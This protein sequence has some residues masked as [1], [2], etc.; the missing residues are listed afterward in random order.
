M[1]G[2]KHTSRF[3]RD[4]R[5]EKMIRDSPVEALERQNTEF[6]FSHMTATKSTPKPTGGSPLRT[7][8]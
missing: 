2:I 1:R 5:R 4:Y 3:K 7:L 6:G 8:A